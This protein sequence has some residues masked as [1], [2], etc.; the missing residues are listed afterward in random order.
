MAEISTLK[1]NNETPANLKNRKYG[2]NWPVVYIINNNEEAYVGETTD[3][4]IR[5]NQHLANNVRRNLDKINIIGDD[6][7]NKSS[8]LDLESFLIKYMAADKRFKLQNG[9]G[10]LQNHNYYQREMYETKF[11]EI[12][13]QLKSK[14]LV[15]N[16]LKMIANSDLFSTKIAGLISQAPSSFE[17]IFTISISI[18]LLILGLY[19]IRKEK[20]DDID[21]AWD[22]IV[23]E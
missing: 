11:R 22:D 12:W 20:W 13:L 9:N 16:D 8:I 19:Y 21:K 17:Y 10:G 23:I 2:T 14:G 6:T 5:A 4:S 7:F 18:F 1:F 3:A 15:K